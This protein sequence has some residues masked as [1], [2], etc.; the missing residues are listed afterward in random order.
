MVAMLA[1][2]DAKPLC[3]SPK[4]RPVLASIHERHEQEVGEANQH[5]ERNE[6]HHRDDAANKFDQDNHKLAWFYI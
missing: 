3:A 5:D 6:N 1:V 4:R 2:A